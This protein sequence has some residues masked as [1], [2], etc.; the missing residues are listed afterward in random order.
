MAEPT[1][2]TTVVMA[3]PSD[4]TTVVMAEPSDRT[5]VVMAESPLAWNVWLTA[6]TTP[7]P[8][9]PYAPQPGTP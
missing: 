1:D 8:S 4:R 6:P 2:R 7:R 9:H 3:E 5:T